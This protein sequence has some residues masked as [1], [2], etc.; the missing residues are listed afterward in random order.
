MKKNERETYWFEEQ[1]RTIEVNERVYQFLCFCKD[2]YFKHDGFKTINEILG[3]MMCEG[4]PRD[5]D[6]WD[7]LEEKGELYKYYPYFAE[8]EE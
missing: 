5:E 3:F 8:D 4:F 1:M 7:Y 2:E 6:F